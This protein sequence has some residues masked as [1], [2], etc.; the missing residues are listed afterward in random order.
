VVLVGSKQFKHEL[1][2]VPLREM[3]LRSEFRPED[4]RTLR[5]GVDAQDMR[6]LPAQ[7]FQDFFGELIN[8]AHTPRV[9]N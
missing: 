1:F 9:L 4:P 5:L 7:M 6:G 3:G 2:F 8:P